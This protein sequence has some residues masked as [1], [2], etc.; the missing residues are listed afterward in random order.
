MDGVTLT[1]EMLDGRGHIDLD[2]P[3]HQYGRLAL[4]LRGRHQV[5][6][7]LTAI[8]LLEELAADGHVA[9]PER[10]IRAAVTDV[11]WP[12]RLE[13]SEMAGVPLL[14][15]GAHNPAGARALA[16]HVRDTYGRRLPMVVGVMRDKKIDALIAALAASASQFVFT[17]P[18]TPRAAP[19]EELLA[20]VRRLDLPV[21]A[22]TSASPREAVVAASA[23]GT[24]VV[25]AG[26]LY[27]AG[28]I[29]AGRP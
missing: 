10:A 11:T 16:R 1:V 7:A 15:D 13:V 2:T 21:P 12:A 9:V 8:R 5:A 23:F 25:V 27:L 24:P 6:N 19:P 29:R 4:A 20:A 26:S 28:E 18:A 3:R 14:I 17:A 22:M